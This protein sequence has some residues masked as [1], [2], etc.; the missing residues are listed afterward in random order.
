MYAYSCEGHKCQVS[1]GPFQIVERTLQGARRLV[2]LVPG[3]KSS[4]MSRPI[5]RDKIHGTPEDLD[6][7]QRELDVEMRT[8]WEEKWAPKT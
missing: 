3:D 8:M 2:R 4:K 6:R 5:R 1:K 7:G